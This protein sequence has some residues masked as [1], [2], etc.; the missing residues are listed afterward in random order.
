MIFLS[1]HVT[2]EFPFKT[3]FLHINQSHLV[4]QEVIVSWFFTPIRS[5]DNSSLQLSQSS[6]PL[7]S[8]NGTQLLISSQATR[9]QLKSL[10]MLLSS[11]H[12]VASTSSINQTSPHFVQISS[13]ISE[14]HVLV[15]P[16]HLMITIS[17]DGIFKLKIYSTQSNK[18]N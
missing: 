8:L 12:S 11:S 5:I 16:S 17:K 7:G 6:S 10:P 13:L 2:F 9:T 4:N 18:L 1:R 3:S 15:Q 14:N